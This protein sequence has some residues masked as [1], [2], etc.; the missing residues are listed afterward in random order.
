MCTWVNSCI[1][2][3]VSYRTEDKMHSTYFSKCKMCDRYVFKLDV[4]FSRT[5]QQVRPNP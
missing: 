3:E 1:A 2:E 4:E 5:L